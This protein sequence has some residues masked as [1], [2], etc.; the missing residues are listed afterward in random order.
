[1]LTKKQKLRHFICNVLIVLHSRISESG[2]GYN[3]KKK[4]LDLVQILNLLLAHE[5]I[6]LNQKIKFFKKEESLKTILGLIV[7][8]YRGR[9]S[10]GNKKIVFPKKDYLIEVDRYH[11]GE[12]IKYLVDCFLK[13]SEKIEFEFDDE[14]KK[15]AIKCDSSLELQKSLST[16]VENLGFLTSSDLDKCKIQYYVA[17]SILKTHC[18]KVTVHSAGIEILL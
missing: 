2:L 10:R 5:R 14:L 13:D 4:A 11:F 7:D 6:L 16:Q 8:I 3:K 17:L 18:R 12:A 15:L 9:I 1:M